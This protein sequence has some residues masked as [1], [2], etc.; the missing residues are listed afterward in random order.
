MKEILVVYAKPYNKEQKASVDIVRKVLKKYGS[1]NDFCERME[2]SNRDFLKKD[3]CV[4]VGGDGTFLRASQFVEGVPLIGLN[5]DPKTKEGFYMRLNRLN[6]EKRFENIFKGNFNTVNLTRLGA[7]I[8]NKPIHCRAL[9]EYYFGAEKSYMT[10]RY[11]ITIS[12]P[13]AQRSSGVIVATPTGT[14]AWAKAIGAK[15]LPRDF[16][17]Y[18]YI[19][20]EPFE[21]KIYSGY[22]YNHGTMEKGEVIKLKSQ[23]EKGI[24]VADSVSKE[25]KV[26]YDDIVTIGISDKYVKAIV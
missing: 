11:V 21:H 1:D 16:K 20:R 24:L 25:H 7:K 5:S 26:K 4:V 10:S 9:N 15:V 17:G 23:M 2:L 19:V 3:L 18:S 13:E 12:K 22:K 14:R 6:F 8:N